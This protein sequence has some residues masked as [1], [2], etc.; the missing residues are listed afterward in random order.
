M[1]ILR[2]YLGDMKRPFHG[3]RKEADILTYTPELMPLENPRGYPGM[4]PVGTVLLF[5]PRTVSLL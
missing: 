4:T 3:A 5:S 2:C 1:I